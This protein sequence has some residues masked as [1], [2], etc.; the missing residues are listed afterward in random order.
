MWYPPYPPPPAPGFSPM[1][2][3]VNVS[4]QPSVLDAAVMSYSMLKT[5][6]EVTGTVWYA[7]SWPNV[8]KEDGIIYMNSFLF[9]E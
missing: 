5:G 3:L 6:E 9:G 4:L 8:L 2:A 7:M 1:E